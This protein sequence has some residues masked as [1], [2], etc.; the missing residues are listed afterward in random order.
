MA[1]TDP[2]SP[3]Y[4]GQNPLDLPEA[5]DERVMRAQP[6]DAV[7]PGRRRPRR[8]A[9]GAGRD[10]AYYA[11]DKKP[12]PI[13]LE[14]RAAF[15]GA[16]NEKERRAAVKA[17]IERRANEVTV[18]LSELTKDSWAREYLKHA[19]FGRVY[20]VNLGQ[21][22]G[23]GPQLHPE[24]VRLRSM[25]LRD[26][27]YQ[28]IVYKTGQ[29][30]MD[31][32]EIAALN[33]RGEGIELEVECVVDPKT[34]D[35]LEAYDL[36]TGR[37]IHGPGL[38]AIEALKC[39]RQYGEGFVRPRWQ[40]FNGRRYDRWVVCEIEHRRMYGAVGG[41]ALGGVSRRTQVVDV[42]HQELIGPDGQ[43][44]KHGVNTG[45]VADGR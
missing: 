35:F 8:T 33:F 32:K 7:P 38:P 23:G 45:S 29:R 13:E 19:L 37:R 18:T 10:E 5:D 12:L 17:V 34:G 26:G 9:A 43:A 39:L 30:E 3:D 11:I 27:A 41:G 6:E 40:R 16:P 31:L 36:T 20:D 28:N 14:M 4:K 15:Q 25:L 2:R 24:G 1:S 44:L 22:R 21:T 42:E